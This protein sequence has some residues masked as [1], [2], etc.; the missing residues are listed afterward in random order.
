MRTVDVS[1]AA[2]VV[3]CS[4]SD[5]DLVVADVHVDHR[6]RAREPVTVRSVRSLD[7]DALLLD[8]LMADWTPMSDAP[9]IEEKWAA[10]LR[11]WSPIIDHHMPLVRKT[12]RHPPCPWL[13]GNQELRELMDERDRARAARNCGPTDAT[14]NAFRCAGNAVKT[15]QSR[16]RSEFYLS[17]FRHSRKTTWRDIRR[18]MIGARRDVPRA[19]PPTENVANWNAKLNE[20]FASV[21]ATVAAEIA[22]ATPEREQLTPRPP[23]VV[24]GAFRVGPATLPELSRALQGMSSSRACGDDGITVQML[25][26]TFPVIG[27]HLLHLVNS[28][29]VSG[30]LPCD[31]KLAVVT[32][33]FKSGNVSEPSNYRPIS[34]LVSDSKFS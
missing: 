12:F 28:S 22:A 16:A 21:G 7:K 14:K 23:R 5:H 26:L 30:Q 9:D 2:R 25:R 18:Y 10:W 19:S 1:T 11:V 3:P 6:R 13:H 15:A 33:L 29:I 34:I 31:W 17:S 8:L 20:Y 27:P 32:P 4:I 24:S